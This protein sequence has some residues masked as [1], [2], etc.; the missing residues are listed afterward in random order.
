M[1]INEFSKQ[2][3]PPFPLKMS[4]IKNNIHI[5][6]LLKIKS[7][8]FDREIRNYYFFLAKGCIS[9]KT[10]K[11]VLIDIETMEGTRRMVLQTI[12]LF[13]NCG[14][15]CYVRFSV[16]YYWKMDKYAKSIITL[17]KVY[18]SRRKTK[19]IIVVSGSEDFLKKNNGSMKI[20]FKMNL[21]QNLEKI[22]TNDFFLPCLLH[23]NL[24]NVNTEKTIYT[25]ALNNVNNERH[26]AALFCGNVNNVLSLDKIDNITYNL[27]LTKNYF[28]IYTRIEM[29][30]YIYEELPGMVYLPTSYEDLIKK[31]KAEE[32]KNKIVLIDTEQIRIPQ[33]KLFEIF[34]DTNFFIYMSGDWQPYCHNH[35]ESMLAGCIPITQ[36]NRFYL[37]N[38]SHIQN[39]LLFNNLI[40]LKEILQNICYD[41]YEKFL[42][43]MRKELLELYKQ[44]FSFES[45]RFKLNNFLKN[46]CDN[47]VY[48]APQ[49]SSENFINK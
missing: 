2:K 5:K 13:L 47:I 35:I 27:N 43:N 48:Y 17:N 33:D 8:L 26:I 20:L 31:T 22:S 41:K 42:V 11:S 3:H 40:E 34:L 38:F 24:F 19:S 4:C 49:T 36:F 37:N 7:I 18:Y 28:S 30:K 32:L 21:L 29:F 39:A 15:T 1:K 44:K 6:I 23:P 9:K 14:L 10:S 46:K 25:A 12:K 45:F 16:N